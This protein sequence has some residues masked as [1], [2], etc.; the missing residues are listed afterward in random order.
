MTVGA[1]RASP[2]LVDMPSFLGSGSLKLIPFFS[3]TLKNK[4]K[5]REPAL[6]R[7]ITHE[8]K[9]SFVMI[10]TNMKQ[11]EYDKCNTF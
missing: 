8:R 3:S 6:T 5:R 11:V 10:I 2:T 9:H 1:M 4:N 7:Y